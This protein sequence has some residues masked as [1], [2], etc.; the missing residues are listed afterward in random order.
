MTS[1]APLEN[2]AR[3]YFQY[4]EDRIQGALS[5]AAKAVTPA[6]KASLE[7]SLEALRPSFDGLAKQFFDPVR[8]QKPDLCEHGYCLLWRLMGGAFNA[9]ARG[10]VSDSAQK[11]TSRIKALKSPRSKKKA[12]RLAGLRRFL[13]AHHPHNW[14]K[15]REFAEQIRPAFLKD[16]GVKEVRGPAGLGYGTK[17]PTVETIYQDLRRIDFL[18]KKHFRP[19]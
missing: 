8:E 17:E 13:Q 15:T 11:Y 19:G 12:E 2:G 5:P 14:V 6:D 16:L 10:M 3:A 4:V 9:G 7:R 18:K 1:P